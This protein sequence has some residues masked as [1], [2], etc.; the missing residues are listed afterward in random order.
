MWSRILLSILSLNWFARVS[1]ETQ[2]VLLVPS[3][4]QSDS[5]QT[6]CVQFH[7]LTETLFVSIV[8]EYGSIQKTLFEES[9]TKNDFFKCGK[10]E[11]PPA[12]SDPLAFI[13]F[14]AKGTTVDLAERR[15]VAI[16]NVDKAVF[17]QTDKPIYK[18]GQTVMF[19]V[20]SL[21][22]QF[23]PVQ[24]TYPRIIM[25]DPEQ[26]KIFQWLEVASKHGIVQLSFPLNPEPILG[27]YDITVETKSGEKK[28]HSFRVEE[29]VDENVFA[30]FVFYCLTHTPAY[31]MQ[32]LISHIHIAFS[33]LPKFEVTTTGPK[34]ISFFDEEVT[35][36][37]CASYSYGQPVQGNAQI[38]VCQWRFYS[39]QCEQN[40]KKACEAVTGQL[41]KDGCLNT[42]ISIKKF[43]LYRSYARMYASLNIESIVTEN[44]TG[45][46]MKAYDYVAV[47]QEKDEVL[48]KN[49]DPYYK[50]GIPYSG[51]ITV[52]NVNGEPVGNKTVLLEVN[53]E[54]LAN[55]TTNKNGTAAFSIDTSNFFDRSFKL[56]VRQAP[57]DCADFSW[58]IQNEPKASFFVRRFYSRTNS[59]LKIE[60][61]PEKLS[62]GQQRKINVH[63]VLN[64]EGYSNATHTTFYYVVQVKFS[65]K[66]GLPGSK[67]GLHLEAAA[68]SYCALR[69]IQSVLQQSGQ[70]LSAESVYYQ[71]GVRDL[72]GYYYNGLNLED[73]KPEGCTPTKTIFFDGLYFE[74][75]NVSR[76]GDVYRIFKDMGLKVFTN[77]MLRKPVL[78]N[79]EESD[80]E[81]HPHLYGADA[82][83]R[84]LME[85]RIVGGSGVSTV[86]KFFPET[87]IWD[88]VHTDSRGEVD[89]I[90]TIPDTITEWKA[91]A[92]CVQDDAGFGITLPVSLTAFQPFFVDLTLPYSVIRGEKFNLIANVFNYL[93]KC[94]QISAL[95]AK[96]S[97]YKA[98]VLSPESNTAR[99]CANERKTYIWAVSPHKLGIKI[100]EPVSLSLPG[101]VVQGSARAYFS[102][103]G[104]I[105]GTALRNLDNLLHMPYGCGEQNMALFTPN[106]YALDY[107]NKTGQLTEEIRVRGTGYL[108]TGYQKQLSYKHWD[109]SYSSFGRRDGEGSVWLTA[110][111]YKSF[112]Q[113]KRYIYID[114]NVQ[115]QTLIWL[116]SKQKS[117][118][119]FENAGSHFNNALKGGEEAEYSLTAY[120][121]AALLEAGHSAAH[122]VVRSGMNCLETAF[123]NGV[124]N[125]YNQALFAYAYGLAGKEKR[126]QFFLEKLDKTAVRDG[127]SVHWQ[128]ENKPPAEHFPDFYSRAPSAEI[129]MTSYVLL[130]LL[131]RTK[132]TPED[133]SY[134]ARIVYW[135]IKQQNPYGGFSSSQ[136]TVVALQALAQYAYLTFSKKSL[137]T[138]E[139]HFMESPS[140]IFQVDDKN[141]FL[142]QQASLPTIPGNYSVEVNGTS[143]VYLQTTLRYN[144]HLPK[145]VA[146]FSLSIR[147]ENVSCTSN[148]PPKFDLVLLAS[149]T[150][151][152]NVS[153]M[154]I[155][156]VKML[157]G[158]VPVD[159]SLK[160]LQDENSVVDRVDIKNNHILFYLQKVSQKEISFSFSVEQSL[161]VSDIKPVPVH[162]YDYYETE[163]NLHFRE[164][165]QICYVISGFNSMK[166]P[167]RQY[168]LMV[169]AVLQNDSPGQVC[170]QFLNLNETISVRA[171]LEYRAVNSTIFEKTMTASSGLQ[172]FNFKIPPVHSSPLAFIFFS[173]KGTTVSLEERRSVM[174]WNTD[175]IVFVQTDKPIYKPGQRVRFRVVALDFNFKPVQ[176][177]YLL[178][179]IE[180][181]RRNRIFQWQNVTSEMNIIQ[182]EFPLTEEPILG[183]YK[184]IVT[185]KSGDRTNHSFLV[186]EYVLP[187]FD[188][189]VTAPESL[190]VL[191][192]E[193]TVKVCGLYTYGQPVEGKVQLSVCRDFD[194]YGRCKKSPVCQSFTK[195]LGIDG[196]LSHVFSS[197]IFELNR[198]GYMR[199]LDVKA[200]VIEKG[201]GLQLTAT[202]FISVTRVIKLVDKDNSP[203]SN[204]VIQLFVNNKNTDNFTTDDNGVAEFSIDTSEMFDPEISLKAIYKT[205]DHCHYEGWI[206]P[207]YPE[208]TVS[209]QRFY[210]W[211]NSFV[212]IEPL[213]KDL[214][215]GQKRMITVHYILNTEV[216][217][218]INT[219]NF[220][221]VGMAKGKIVLTGELK[222]NIKVGQ[223]GT[224]TIPLVVNEKM[225]PTLRLL[226]YT[227]HPAKELV[228]DSVLFPVEK[229]FKNKVH[230]QF[231]EKQMHPSS[232]V[233]L[234]IEAAANSF[235]AV[236]AVDQSVLLLK[237]ET[238]LSVEMIYSLH[239][240]Q[241]F[242]GY[243][244][245]GFNLEEDR[246]DPC[247]SSDH[248]FHK[249]LYYTPVMSGL[250]PDV[251]E[252]LRDMGMKLFTNSKVRQPV[253]CTSETVRRQPYTGFTAHAH[254]V[255]LSGEASREE[256]EKKHIL[257][258]IR[259]FFPET[260]IWDI[261][262]INSTGKASISYT[263]PD[264]ITKWNASAFCVEELIG[265]GMSLPATLTAFQPFF[266]DLTLPY[267]I[268]RGED[269]LLRANAFNYLDR[270][271]K[272]NVLLSDSPDFRAKL[273]STD[274]EGCLCA[275]QRKTYVWNIFPK[276]IGNVVFSIT[277]ETKDDESCGDK[278]HR[279]ISIDYRDTQ[280]RTLLVEPE[281]IRREKTQNSLICTEGDI[282]GTAMQNLHQLLQMP[283]GCG[284]QNMVLFAPN[285][286]ILDYLNK[287]GQ[288][289]EKVRSKAIGYLV[290]GYQKQLSYKHPDG[291]YSI[292]GTRDKEGNTW[293]TAF[294]YRSFAQASHFIYIDDNVQSQTLMWLASKQKPDGCFRSVGTLFNNALKGGV[295]G[296]L[297]LSAYTTIAMLEGGH[298]ILDPVIRNALF[299][300]ETAS[301]KS[302]SDVYT[303][304]LMAY[305]FCLAG[306][307]EKCQSFLEE[308]QKSAK[309]VDGSWH[310]EQKDRSPSEESPSFLDHAPSAE[311]EITS[312]VLLA[313]LYKLNRNKEDL[314]KASRIVQWIIRQQNP[315]G[316]FS[317]TQDTVIALQALATYGKATYNSA[318]QNGVKIT[319]KESFEKTALR[320]NIRLPEGAFGFLLSVQTSNAS[321]PL[322][323]PAKFD[324]FLRSSYT[325]KRSSSNMLIIDVKMLS[326]FVPVK[327]SL[328]KLIDSNTVMQVENK[329][330]HVLLYLQNI[331]QKKK[332]E[333][334]FSVEQDFIVTNPKPAPVQIYDYYETEE[335][336]VSQYTSPCKEVV[337]TD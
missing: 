34:R 188:V 146:G 316:G 290:S 239:P 212:R 324:I 275:K 86:R 288:L 176:E 190:T 326:G 3:V 29:Y 117:D 221:Y 75:V 211:T 70:E 330:N 18:P 265:F 15:S 284:E 185:K 91:S 98:E 83:D 317:S 152:R 84:I 76:D 206:E 69:A 274:D 198:T 16:Q 318:T 295:D 14:S 48:F 115:S 150:G 159:S 113:A 300:L 64:R 45:I 179:A 107:L 281:G 130:A 294:V 63:Y 189:T 333:I 280:I 286:Y 122:P 303:Q 72:Y 219:V 49:M 296:E 178:I 186:E 57:D 336:A 24:E 237:P 268:I 43:Q 104:D 147:M 114:D 1:S 215:C 240:L 80:V 154:A 273:L 196:C 28:Y 99:V 101:N 106:I 77:S 248:I 266:V 236:R 285:I 128:R 292:F 264:T 235:C 160:K 164:T 140:K 134:I 12:T 138:V 311:V 195:N 42:V 254:H 9:V 325:G 202:Q 58:G 187:K 242:Q 320:Y 272:I 207:Y 103:I 139:V 260:W 158:F 30:N 259:E 153:N 20:V 332:K 148:Y 327:S 8:L 5:P 255:K 27:S 181:P 244:F 105:L 25:E 166:G 85:S 297:S 145:K 129:E 257:E 7:N 22:T 81:D 73:G 35:V 162:I 11:V 38:N 328:D 65:E 110:F 204:E 51:E 171:I 329:K 121:V 298:S 66:Q 71:L 193:F 301:E 337:E 269:F 87:W 78:C 165:I 17:I 157:S 314:T 230:L 256:H 241:D 151:K 247:V 253:I 39:P 36:K 54:Y 283:F 174:I 203:I 142:L 92:F 95:L 31:G 305:A 62:C 279:N 141:R 220:Y 287:T 191:D 132:L 246:Q 214:G 112:A 168:V 135:L 201:T 100:S 276:E 277:A 323:R 184:I 21:D 310:W 252:F 97:D 50:R 293:L 335:Y 79:E 102:V 44:G 278:A 216:Y 53:E 194:S 213:W 306:K 52:T 55:Y 234:V 177:T 251:Y 250:G 143:C 136:D 90:Y 231:S 302:I 304:A 209:I 172:C 133:L 319:S 131:N 267:S 331:S 108:S 61:V 127:G 26:N 119:C 245:N 23:R 289:S 137:N 200:I 334:I 167:Y 169:P 155:I 282:M 263:I 224:F 68:N 2:Y 118:G 291:S 222:V 315:Y 299:C 96:S 208:V 89:V 270:C 41:G 180:D 82:S 144:I 33:V 126:H 197:N 149:Y 37:V 173:A 59:F 218:S 124:H 46:Q 67:V 4:V 262:L 156:D 19:R 322:D 74:P 6:A 111:V 271:I 88:L 227:L 125:L 175:S 309:E 93:N 205:S 249:G 109:G 233:S 10:F 123:S 223:N 47:N 228:A 243:V 120:V 60:P 313:L 161:P 116:A 308:L 225:A 312:Y 199:N 56:T 13:S 32:L 226:V 182:K 229:C 258:T 307:A 183:N 94:V 40:R 321:C 163:T 261:V 210:S 170:L 238:E 232:N 217:E 192:L